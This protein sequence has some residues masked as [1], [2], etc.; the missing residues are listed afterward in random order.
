MTCL[1]SPDGHAL[2]AAPKVWNFISSLRSFA[3]PSGLAFLLR[4]RCCLWVGF[5]KRP[6]WR[7]TL[8]ADAW[9]ERAELVLGLSSGQAE[10][11]QRR[12]CSGVWG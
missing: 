3:F 7:P 8:P 9:P 10:T 5:S 6:P 4:K 12:G 1:R 11:W 2:K